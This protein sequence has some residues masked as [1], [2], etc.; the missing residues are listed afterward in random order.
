M[1]STEED[2]D[3]LDA[4]EFIGRLPVYELF[5][6]F[7]V[8]TLCGLRVGSFVTIPA[9]YELDADGVRDE[10]WFADDYSFFLI[11]THGAQLHVIADG[12]EPF[13]RTVIAVEAFARANLKSSPSSKP[14][15]PSRGTIPETT[16]RLPG[17]V[18]RTLHP[19][20]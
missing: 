15:R 13:L 8:P 18:T 9:Q 11:G 16:A 3:E 10:E 5:E 14:R 19:L 7:K 12:L 2:D 20:P 6:T 17:F 4:L 1:S